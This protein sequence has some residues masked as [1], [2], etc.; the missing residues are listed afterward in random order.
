[1]RKL[2][3]RKLWVSIVRAVCAL[4]LGFTGSIEWTFA[5]SIIAGALGG[6]LGM[7][8]LADALGRLTGK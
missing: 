1:M 8:G 6:Y 2:T 5:I 4:I 7:E 3:S